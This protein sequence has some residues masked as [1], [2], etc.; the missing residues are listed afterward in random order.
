[1]NTTT[2]NAAGAK[3]PMTPAE[4]G[5]LV[6]VYRDS[7]EWSQETLAELAGVTPRTVQRV[8][9]GEPSSVDTRRALARA[10]QI[11]DMDVFLKSNPFPTQEEIEQQKA[12]FDRKYVL[13]AATVIDGRGIATMFSGGHAYHAISS[14]SVVESL[15]REAQDTFAAVLDYTRDCMD[16][17]DVASNR[18]M[19]SY[20]D[21]LEE[22]ISEL[23]GTGYCVCSAVRHISLT[24][25]SWVDKT[26][27]PWTL[28]Y[29][30]IAPIKEPPAK[31]V[32]PRQ[33]S[34]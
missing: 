15:P 2:K 28:L 31:I 9:A 24:S 20:G 5:F 29:L 3:P 18:D 4:V 11:P 6:K 34:L 25:K 30:V 26:P 33:V 8:E 12:E 7:M 13:L 10:F 22:L 1:M 27:M 32:V 23:R 19:L 17:A 21:G 16:V 14:G